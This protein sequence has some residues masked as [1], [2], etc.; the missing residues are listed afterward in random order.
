MRMPP[1]DEPIKPHGLIRF[2][3]VLAP[4]VV[5][6]FGLGEIDFS[7]YWFIILYFPMI[8]WSVYWTMGTFRIGFNKLYERMKGDPDRLRIAKLRKFYVWYLNAPGSL[9][10][11]ELVYQAYVYNF[12]G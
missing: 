8:N 4:I 5:F 6:R 9:V 10:L 12:A 2:L 11:S 1:L 3:I 7:F